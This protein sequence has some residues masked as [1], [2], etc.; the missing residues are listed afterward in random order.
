MD[1]SKETI[2]LAM[3]KALIHTGQKT[4]ACN[5]LKYLMQEAIKHYRM[6]GWIETSFLHTMSPEDHETALQVLEEVIREVVAQRYPSL[7][8]DQGQPLEKLIQSLKN[9][10]WSPKIGIPLSVSVT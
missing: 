6:N 7:F 5:L 8:L 9:K 10:N 3:C 4:A 2:L 1:D